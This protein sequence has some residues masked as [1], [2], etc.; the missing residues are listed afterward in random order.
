MGSLSF[1]KQDILWTW[2]SSVIYGVYAVMFAGCVYILMSRL[3]DKVEDVVNKRLLVVM[4][5]LFV[6]S[7]VTIVL[8]VVVELLTVDV[9]ACSDTGS[10]AC[11]LQKTMAILQAVI[12]PFLLFNIL[13]GDGLWLW[14]CYMVWQAR[15]KV[16][17]F[18]CFLYLVTIVCFGCSF[19]FYLYF[20]VAHS[21]DLELDTPPLLI[22]LAGLAVLLFYV[23]SLINVG[24]LTCLI[25]WR[26]ISVNGGLR[27][28][29]NVDRGRRYQRIA[30]LIIESGVMYTV[31]T[32]GIFALSFL[33]DG[34]GL[35]LFP[36]LV[37][38]SATM[39]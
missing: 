35:G 18:S 7:T 16:V 11:P 33:Q 22:T 30:I 28:H 4:I 15:L 36:N 8:D 1:R 32:V 6:S 5:L 14:R 39:E 10:E 31:C 3:T 17:I 19:G 20:S 25:S 27:R 12:V 21:E 38:V 26:I 13:I 9:E 2:L 34:T 37:A 24:I 29:L 23:I